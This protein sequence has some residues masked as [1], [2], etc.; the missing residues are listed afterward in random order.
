M[1]IESVTYIDDLNS[2]YPAASDQKSEGDDH[3]RNIKAAIKATFPNIDAPVT[4]DEVELNYLDGIT[5]REL[6]AAT[7]VNQGKATLP[8]GLLMIWGGFTSVGTSAKN[9]TVTFG[10]TFSTAFLVGGAWI[11]G[12]GTAGDYTV[13]IGAGS[14]TNLEITTMKDGAIAGGIGGAFIA[15][16]Y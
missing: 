14:T 8:G 2:S 10:A 11:Y 15:I 7:G 1:T 9:A 3:I 13:Q 12:T 6:V 16:G 5:S 4:A